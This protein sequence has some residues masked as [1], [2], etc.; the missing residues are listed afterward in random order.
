MR[1]PSVARQPVRPSSVANAPDVLGVLRAALSFPSVCV[2]V[3]PCSSVLAGR[4][5]S[6]KAILLDSV[7]DPVGAR[8]RSPPGRKEYS[9]VVFG[10]W[11]G[12]N[13]S[14]HGLRFL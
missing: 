4:E 13:G 2:R 7:L 1:R 3:C 6:H 12:L 9:S 11:E 10:L 5:H 14:N 8:C